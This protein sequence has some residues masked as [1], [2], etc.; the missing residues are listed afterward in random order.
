M[1]EHRRI[2]TFLNWWVV[3]VGLILKHTRLFKEV[4]KIVILYS[5][6]SV[7]FSPYKLF[8]CIWISEI[9]PLHIP[10]FILKLYS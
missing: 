8:S 2:N 3:L 6:D 4:T 1:L 5:G 10:D 7:F 9:D